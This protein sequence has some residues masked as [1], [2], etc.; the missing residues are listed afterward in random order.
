M[1]VNKG[2]HRLW[3]I[4]ATVGP[5]LVVMLADTEAG[6]VITSAQSGAEWGYRLLLL[7]F[8]CIP[9]LF[10]I[11]EL[12]IRLG[13]GTGKG[14]G[15]LIRLRFGRGMA[16]VSLA[17]LVISCFGELV[18][19]MSGL[20]GVGQLFGVASWQ[21]IS[22]VVILI[23][24]MVWTGSYHSVERSAML[25][26]LFGIAFLI[27]AWKS[28]P[29]TTQVLAQIQH[30]PFGNTRYLY[31]VAANLG[32]CIMPWTMFYQQSA[33]VDKG[34]TLP[35]LKIARTETLI[36][37]LL[38][39]GLQAAVLVAAAASLGRHGTSLESVP[40]IA[41]AFTAV[42]GQNVGRIVFAVGLCGSAL[43]ATIVVCL[44]VAWS[45]GEVI[46]VRNSLEQ[47]PRDV[48]WFYAAFG[49]MLLAG[50]ALVCSGINLV[51][52]SIATGVINAVLLPAVLFYLYRLACTELPESL[53]LK[54]GYAKLIAV[55][56]SITAMLGLY[57]GI[58]GTLG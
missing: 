45:T 48:P 46:G 33:L 11:Q 51:R 32:T 52:L 43:V 20:A 47:S 3:R 29:N 49:I 57:A 53:R 10:M 25:L 58:V 56:F 36:G 30:M 13:L 26:G 23:F 42:L 7:Q 41:E 35:H 22:V 24:T 12:T 15:E 2:I 54:G 55:V 14:Y 37:A 38:C 9:L 4:A 21:T 5:G 40:Q 19:Q 27:V 6:S 34:L 1:K 18:T 17:I 16:F 28:H 39:Q 8:F 31:L 44:T 50:G